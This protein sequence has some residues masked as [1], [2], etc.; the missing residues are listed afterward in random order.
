MSPTRWLHAGQVTSPMSHI[1]F[2]SDISNL[3]SGQPLE[4][5]NAVLG[6]DDTWHFSGSPTERSPCLIKLTTE[7]WARLAFR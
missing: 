2:N 1:V 3:P 4:S 7:V 5:K 6:V